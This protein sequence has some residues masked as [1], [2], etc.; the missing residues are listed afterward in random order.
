MFGELKPIFRTGPVRPAARAL[1]EQGRGMARDV[2]ARAQAALA[3]RGGAALERAVRRLEA[4][5]EA[6]EMGRLFGAEPS[7]AEADRLALEVAALLDRRA[8]G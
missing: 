4:E 1:V 3:E 8:D 5:V 7:G 2:L 6:Q